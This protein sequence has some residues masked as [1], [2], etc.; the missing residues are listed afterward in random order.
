MQILINGLV[1]GLAIALLAVAFQLVYLPT[2]VFFLGLAGVYTVAPFLAFAVRSSGGRW[3][4]AIATATGG[5]ILLCL[6]SEWANHARLARRQASEGAQLLSSLGI[7]LVLVQVVAMVW[8]N[9][10]KTLRSG[11]D[12]VV[13]PG[14]VVITGAQ[15]WI[16]G[17][18]TVLLIAFALLLMHSDLGLR[19]RALS[20]NPTQFALLGYNV[21][22]Y[23]LLAFGLSGL[24]AAAAS[25]AT[26]YDV[27]FD[28]QP[29]GSC[30]LII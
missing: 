10:S 4:G 6:L 24:F 5:A 21:D 9:D 28:P 16:G 23:R 3:G 25:V 1:S 20:D 8:G 11:L 14:G 7:Y 17:L 13:R 12:Y 26:A 22:R 2:R 29:A 27:G 15:L 18:A 19:L 30:A